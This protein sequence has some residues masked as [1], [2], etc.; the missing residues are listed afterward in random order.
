MNSLWQINVDDYFEIVKRSKEAGLKSGDDMTPIF[1][2]YMQEK[3]QKPIANTELTKE[4][5]INEY[6]S[7]NKKVLDI[8]VDEKGKSNYKIYKKG[9]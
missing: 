6:L 4:E 3:G 7:H 9:K 5:M 8:S 1:I 2:K